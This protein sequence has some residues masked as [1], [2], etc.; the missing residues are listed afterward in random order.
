MLTVVGLSALGA[1]SDPGT[2]RPMADT[3]F[4]ANYHLAAALG[5]LAVVAWTYYRVWLNMAVN[6]QVIERIVAQVGRI[7]AERGLDEPAAAERSA[8]V[9]QG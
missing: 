4:W 8:A 2:G 1:A 9:S 6:Q 7:R 3:A 5:G